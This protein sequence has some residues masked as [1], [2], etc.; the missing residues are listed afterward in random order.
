MLAFIIRIS[1]AVVNC[2]LAISPLILTIRSVKDK[3]FH[4]GDIKF[5]WKLNRISNEYM[6]LFYLSVN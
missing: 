4:Y 3:R 5:N 1:K 6:S 2:G